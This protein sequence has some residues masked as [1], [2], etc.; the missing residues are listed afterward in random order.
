VRL[1]LYRRLADLTEDADLHA[2]G[3]ELHDR[4]GRLPEEVNHLLAVVSIKLLCRRANVASLDAG[5]KGA[6]ISFRDGKF[7][8]PAALVEW[9]TGQGTLA[10]LRPDMKLVIIR[11]WNTP[12]ERLKGSRQLMTQLVKLAS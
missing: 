7:A 12:E 11:T 4:F 2:F 8:N 6:L 5:P 1:G 10:K 3:A 9:I